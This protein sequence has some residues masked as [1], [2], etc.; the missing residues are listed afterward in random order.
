MTKK[1]GK[2]APQLVPWCNGITFLTSNQKIARSNR[3]GITLLGVC[4]CVGS[5]VL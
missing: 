4:L 1:R 3:A 5:Q 2:D